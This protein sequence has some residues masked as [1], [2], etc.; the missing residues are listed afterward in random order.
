MLIKLA[1]EVKIMSATASGI[2][3]TRLGQIAINTKDADRAAAF[4]QDQLGLSL[5]FKAPPGLAFFDCGG[6]RLMLERAEK[7]EFDHPSSVLYFVVPN[8][9]AAYDKLKK[10]GVRFEDDPHL[11]ARM[12]TYDLWMTFFRDSE[13]NLLAL[14]SEVAR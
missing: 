2:G 3:I 5:L 12:P 4:Y 8:I 11:I 7:P 1:L 9:Q 6:V 13:G 14:M 10:N